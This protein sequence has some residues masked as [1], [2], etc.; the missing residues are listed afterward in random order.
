MREGGRSRFDGGERI[1]LKRCKRKKV[2]REEE[3]RGRERKRDEGT[4]RK[5]ARK[6]TEVREKRKEGGRRKE[7]EGN[8]RGWSSP[9]G[10]CKR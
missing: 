7:G 9:L 2:G 4:K 10:R 1:V 6:D 5:E 3:K 8:V